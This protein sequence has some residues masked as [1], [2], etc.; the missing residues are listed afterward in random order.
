MV[1]AR[2]QVRLIPAQVLRFVHRALRRMEQA[3]LRIMLRLE[4]AVTTGTAQQK[5]M[6]AMVVARVQVRLIPAQALRFVHRAIRKM[7]QR[8]L[9]TMPLHQPLVMMEIVVP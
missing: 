4:R 7:A 5:M 8:V 6:C 9:Q 3:V 1:V 2:V